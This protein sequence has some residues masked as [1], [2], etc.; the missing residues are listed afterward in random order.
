[1]FSQDT[2]HSDLEI[3]I[4]EKNSEHKCELHIFQHK[5]IFFHLTSVYYWIP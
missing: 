3:R 4:E 5:S 2:Q 1:M